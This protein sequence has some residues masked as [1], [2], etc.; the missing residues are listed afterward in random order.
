MNNSTSI[1]PHFATV[2]GNLSH[3]CYG[4]FQLLLLLLLVF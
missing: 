1:T 4:L 2:W 3:Y